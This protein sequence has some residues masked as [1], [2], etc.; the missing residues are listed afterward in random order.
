MSRRTA[1]FAVLAALLL[2]LV[3][4]AIKSKSPFVASTSGGEFLPIT[5]KLN[6]GWQLYTVED[7]RSVGLVKSV[8][9]NHVFPDGKTQDGV[10]I[11]LVD[12]TENW[13]PLETV[14]KLYVAKP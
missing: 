14:K 12:A 6:P 3:I 9:N 11:L 1:F 8:E 7:H 4:F 10:L 13:V 2:G 5:T